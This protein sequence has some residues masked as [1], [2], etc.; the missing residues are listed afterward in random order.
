MVRRLPFS[1]AAVTA[2][3]L[4]GMTA[5]FHILVLVEI[6]PIAQVWG[7][8]LDSIADMRVYESASLA[9]TAFIAYTVAARAQFVASPLW[10]GFLRVFMRFLAVMFVL[11]AVGNAASF[12]TVEAWVLTPVAA[13][14]A[15]VFWRLGA[16]EPEVDG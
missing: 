7:G 6:I 8:R 13:V 1:N 4:L 10:A 2:L 16:R 11:N 3:V 15:V 9:I 14:L 5:I 12:S